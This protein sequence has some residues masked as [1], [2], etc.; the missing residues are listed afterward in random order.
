M[1]KNNSRNVNQLQVQ[2]LDSRGRAAEERIII[3][4]V[5]HHVITP[6]S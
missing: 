3:N 6:A 1:I 4:N 2:L 5:K